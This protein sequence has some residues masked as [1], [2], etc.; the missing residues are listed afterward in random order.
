MLL[1]WDAILILGWIPYSNLTTP[2]LSVVDVI[3]ESR[4]IYWSL[5][6]VVGQ[7]QDI[8]LAEWYFIASAAA[9]NQTS[10]L[11]ITP[12]TEYVYGR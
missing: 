5:P 4:L 12:P 8:T 6:G 1:L 11:Y 2:L 10:D 3:P 9:V 7:L